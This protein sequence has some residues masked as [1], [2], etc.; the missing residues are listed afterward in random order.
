MELLA[1]HLYG[2][3]KKKSIKV[4]MLRCGL[5]KV[6]IWVEWG[7]FLLQISIEKWESSVEESHF[8]SHLGK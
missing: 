2:N 8:V 4:M 5:V 1:Q 3:P 7:I 6:S